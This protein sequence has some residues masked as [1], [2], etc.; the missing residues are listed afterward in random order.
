[1]LGTT[2]DRPSI[3][4]LMKSSPY[5]YWCKNQECWCQGCV[6]Q[7]MYRNG[8]S[9]NEYKQWLRENTNDTF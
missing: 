9:E 1:M 8:Y 7:L 4:E 3:D 2:D 5:R 6:N